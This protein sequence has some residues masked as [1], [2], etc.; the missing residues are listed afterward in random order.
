MPSIVI[1]V[2]KDQKN[3]NLPGNTAKSSEAP[4]GNSS[5]Q[6]SAS[7][8]ANEASKANPTKVSEQD[9]EVAVKEERDKQ[10]L[11]HSPEAE[12]HK[13]KLSK[14][15]SVLSHEAMVSITAFPL[16]GAGLILGSAFLLPALAAAGTLFTFVGLASIA[17]GIYSH[18]SKRHKIKKL[19]KE[20]DEI[21]D[22]EKKTLKK[23]V[24]RN[25][26]KRFGGHFLEFGGFAGAAAAVVLTG[27]AATLTLGISLLGGAA[28]MGIGHAIAKN[29]HNGIKDAVEQAYKP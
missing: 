17:Y 12:N 23:S 9:R 2:D 11:R 28:V 27:A 3:Q 19:I 16:I 24:V 1:E 15:L 10:L 14:T 4:N 6:N 13:K 22:S 18:F 5:K 25:G 8:D 26:A 29:S 7:S 20:T 21:P